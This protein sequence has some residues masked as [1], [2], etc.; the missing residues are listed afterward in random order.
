M[1]KGVLLNRT[2]N[3]EDAEKLLNECLE[4]ETTISQKSI[5]AAYLVSTYIHSEKIDDARRLY[6]DIVSKYPNS[7]QQGYLIRNAASAYKENRIE[8]YDNAL[9]AFESSN[10]KFGYYTTLCNKGYYTYLNGNCDEALEILRKSAD[11]IEPFTRTNLHIVYNNIGICY[12]SLGQYDEARQYLV[13]ADE[14]GI[15]SMPKLFSAINLACLLSITGQTDIA[16][17]KIKSLEDDIEKHPLNRVRQKY[18]SNR[19]LIEYLSGN[20][21]MDE[22]V[23]KIQQHPDRYNPEKTQLYQ[24]FYKQLQ[25]TRKEPSIDM[26]KKLFSPCGLVYW[27]IDPLKLFTEITLN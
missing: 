24:R 11:G 12:M 20:R 15:N 7:P 5:I 18:Y 8:M 19:F 10:D 6:N 17:K 14:I 25:K 2:R 16:L 22:L 27:Y 21:K 1:L 26:W 23:K 9:S 13:I 3:Q 4:M